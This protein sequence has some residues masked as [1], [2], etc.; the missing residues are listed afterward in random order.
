MNKNIFSLGLVLL[1]VFALTAK[2]AK[3]QTQVKPDT[4]L[5]M[6]TAQQQQF[7]Q[8]IVKVSDNVFTAVGFHGANT[9]MIVRIGNGLTTSGC[10]SRRSNR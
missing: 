5:R 4:A 2:N 9:S 6:L 1:G 10:E 8:G 7:E 3:G